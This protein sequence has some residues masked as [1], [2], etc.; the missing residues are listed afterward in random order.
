MNAMT[1]STDTKLATVPVTVFVRARRRTERTLAGQAALAMLH[2]WNTASAALAHKNLDAAAAVVVGQARRIRPARAPRR[3]RLLLRVLRRERRHDERSPRL[4][5]H[6]RPGQAGEV[7][8]PRGRV[9]VP[10][11]ARVRALVW[12]QRHT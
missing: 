4:A 9:R 8:A 2:A 7:G 12:R 1:I 6:D 5:E 11:G 3:A 10:G